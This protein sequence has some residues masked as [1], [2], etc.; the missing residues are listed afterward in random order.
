M[1]LPVTWDW[2]FGQ[3]VVT[4]GAMQVLVS[5]IWVWPVAHLGVASQVLLPVT[6]D[7][8]F[9]QIVVTGSVMQRLVPSR[10]VW[11]FGHTGVGETQRLVVGE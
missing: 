4:G 1:L 8:P 11:P 5:A 7:W 6:W 9:G 2:P 10:W 3:V